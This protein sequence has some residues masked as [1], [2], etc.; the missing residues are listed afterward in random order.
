MTR[1]IFLVCF[2]AL[3]SRA[4]DW[5]QLLGP[6]RDGVSDE[7][8]IA[9][10]WGKEGPP[11]LWRRSVGQG[12][13]APVVASNRPIIFHRLND[14]EVVEC[15]DAR[16]GSAIWKSDYETDYRDDFGF[17]EGPRATPAIEGSRVF[18]FGANGVLNAWAV[19]NGAKLWRVNTRQKFQTDKGFFGIAA[20][21]LV[22]GDAVIVNVGGNGAGIVAFA[23]VT[24][25]VL[26]KVTDDEASYSSPVAATFGG[27]RRVLVLTRAN[28]VALE[29]LTGKVL[30]RFP[31]RPTIHASVSAATPLVIGDRIFISGSYGAG[32]AMLR[33]GEMKPEV[34]WRNDDVLS[35][36][37]ATSVARDGFLFGFDGRQELKCNLR[38]ID[39]ASGKVRWNEERFGA[40]TILCVKDQLVILTERGELIVAPAS[41]KEFKP[42]A[43]AQILG[44]DCR[45]HAALADGALYARDKKSLICV[46]LRHVK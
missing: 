39:A 23:V 20:S 40:G 9:T 46:D 7:T 14:R 45:A 34:L 8:N 5:P 16:N 30:W 18:T 32:A 21:P 4:N 41:E 36:H 26:W 43:R 11:V 3:L 27:K 25:D 35:N 24:G 2:V 31:F 42:T 15:L 6:H 37:Y 10:N 1:F 44:A 12:W 19:T 13:S 33:F 38:C 28:L 17:D 29:P 22:E